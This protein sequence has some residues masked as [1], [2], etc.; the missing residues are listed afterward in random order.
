MAVTIWKEAGFF[1]I[2]FLAALQQ[3]SPVLYERPPR[4]KARSAGTSSAAS[5][6]RW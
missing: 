5:P 4:W 2:F 1:M 3:V 6:G